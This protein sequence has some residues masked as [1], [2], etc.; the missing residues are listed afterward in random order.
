[1]LL[2]GKWTAKSLLSLKIQ[3]KKINLV[4]KLAC[5]EQFWLQ[6]GPQAKKSCPAWCRQFHQHFTSSFLSPISL[7]EKIQIQ[8]L[9]N[10]DH[11]SK[12]LA[13]FG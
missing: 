3:I 13:I 8:L 9:L 12:I 7:A 10:T 1:M 5:I 2:F 11:N 4:L 6:C